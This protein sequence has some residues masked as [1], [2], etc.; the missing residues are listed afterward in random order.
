MA[1][2]KWLGR[3]LVSEQPYN[4]Y[5]QSMQYAYWKR[6]NGLPYLTAITEMQVKSQIARP[7]PH[8]VVAAGKPYR[9]FGAAWSGMGPVTRV[10]VS[11]DGGKSWEPARLTGEAVRHSWRLWEHEWRVPAVPGRQVLM[12]R[13][14][15]AAG[16]VQPMERDPDR[17]NTMISHV[18]PIVVEMR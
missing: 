7:A 8:E 14:T 1:S 6:A 5:F 2:V 18:L 9:V 17:R 12:S 4:G 10:E 15:D 16:R 11:T 13:A 3:I